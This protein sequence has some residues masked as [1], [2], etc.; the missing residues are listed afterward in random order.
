MKILRP[1]I[2]LISG[3]LLAT[4]AM[5]QF[6][7][8]EEAVKY[9]QGVMAVMDFHLYR[10]IGSMVNGRIPLDAKAAV[11]NANLLATL[12]A[13]PWMAFGP[14]LDVGK[15]DAKPAIWTEQARFKDLS[16]KM[17]AEVVKLQAA[18]RTGDIEALKTAYR[19]TGN[20]CKAC[21]DRYTSQ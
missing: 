4:A 13:L 6:R 2:V 19:A 21:H 14:G 16:E 10:Q 20:S 17:Q 18:A 15:S 8:P 7:K 3:G 11:E 1:L 12:S 5:A 9:R